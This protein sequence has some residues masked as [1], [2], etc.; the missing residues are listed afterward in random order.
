MPDRVRASWSG[1]LVAV[2]LLW[3]TPTGFAQEF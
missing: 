2:V 1:A 3:P